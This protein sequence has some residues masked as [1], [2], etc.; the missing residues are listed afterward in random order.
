MQQCNCEVHV[1]NLV[2][3]TRFC[4]RC[5]QCNHPVCAQLAC[6][7]SFLTCTVLFAN[8]FVVRIRLICLASTSSFACCAGQ[9]FV[10][11]PIS[12]KLNENIEV[13]QVACQDFSE[14]YEPA[15]LTDKM[16]SQATHIMIT[17]MCNIL[18][19]FLKLHACSSP[20]FSGKTSLSFSVSSL[21]FHSSLGQ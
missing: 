13:I 8:F 3:V 12:E 20:D 9:L 17:D 14:F 2:S 16:C 15:L 21:L 5:L 6:M 7:H 19:N 18:W 1:I 10:T 4:K 11:L